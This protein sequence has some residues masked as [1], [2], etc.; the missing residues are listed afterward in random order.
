[1]WQK[2]VWISLALFCL[3][4]VFGV[5]RLS[6][7]LRKPCRA[8]TRTQSSAHGDGFLRAGGRLSV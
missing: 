5:A 8:D 1:M 2:P 7:R 4:A 3:S 6:V